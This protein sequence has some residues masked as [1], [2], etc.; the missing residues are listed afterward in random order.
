MTDST[1]TIT[2]EKSFTP[3]G[4]VL[5]E[6]G[7]SKSEYGYT[8]EV[9]DPSGLVYLRARYYLPGSGRFIQKDQFIGYATIPLS[10]NSFIYAYSNPISFHD[11][12]GFD[13]ITDILEKIY[14][15]TKECFEKG[16][17]KCVERN[18]YLIA[19]GGSQVAGLAS[20]H[21]Y[22]FLGSGKD[23]TY[24]PYKRPYDSHII[25]S[26]VETQTGINILLSEIKTGIIEQIQSGSMSGIKTSR[27]RQVEPKSD[28]QLYFAFNK[29]TI[30]IEAEYKYNCDSRI[31]IIKPH[32]RFQ[33]TYNW[34]PGFIAGGYYEGYWA[35]LAKFKD[36]WTNA[37]KT[38]G[39][40]HEFDINGYWDN[41]KIQQF[42]N[43]EN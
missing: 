40:A 23:I 38:A 10:N 30:W 37:L 9:T 19:T 15:S 22:N 12:S 8:G 28:P 32:I 43:I 18:Y 11:P 33:D 13:P 17:L 21:L 29:F 4:D 6:S 41:P 36:D 20:A 2:L 5:S 42:I 7:T 16:D 34:H 26:N 25:V 24:L 31:A 1:G 14:Q 35:V 27:I 3:F 39:M